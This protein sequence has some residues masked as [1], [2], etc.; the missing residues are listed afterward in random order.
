MTKLLFLQIYFLSYKY[1]S[2]IIFLRDMVLTNK[3]AIAAPKVMY[4]NQLDASKNMWVKNIRFEKK[5]L[6]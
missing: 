3:L 2:I 4:V 5:F 6:N 1:D